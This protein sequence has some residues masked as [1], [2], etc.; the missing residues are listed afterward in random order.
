MAQRPR[1]HALQVAEI[2]RLTDDSV[3]LTFAVPDEVAADYA[4]SPGQHVT[5]RC[6]AAGDDGRR[7]YSLCSPPGRLRIGVKQVASGVFS[8]H[9]LE[10]MRIGDEVDVMTPMGRFTTTIDPTVARHRVGIVAGS[11]ITPVLSIMRATLEA[12]PGSRFTLIYGNRSSETV[13]FLEEI[14]DLKDRFAGRLAVFHVL[15]REPRESA[16][17]SGRLD[18]SK[19]EELLDTAVGARDVD[20]WFR[21]RDVDEWFLCGPMPM[22]DV[23]R[24]VLKSRGIDDHAVHFELFHVATAEPVDVGN[25][26]GA[27]VS[28]SGP[29]VSAGAESSLVQIVLAGRTSLLE[30]PR[31]RDVLH[32]VMPVRPDVPYGCTNG[33][34]GTCRAKVV[35]GEVEMDHCYAL[36]D[37]ELAAGFVLTCQAQP[38]T[39]KVV[40]DYDA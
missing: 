18:R 32:A 20:E 21:C 40:L 5:V 6:L 11:G 7:T 10:R 16:M 34:C 3:A 2:E 13:M 8:T 9:A 26:V 39:G 31:T 22:V 24:S 30:V 23:A 17:L 38:R 4:F 14:A 37:S 1:F 36:D 33:M 28:S 35:E 12:E 15:S 25:A 27:G 29:R 19:L